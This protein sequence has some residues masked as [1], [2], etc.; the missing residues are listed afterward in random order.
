MPRLLL[1]F[2]VAH[3]R[4]Y[5]RFA[6]A[7]PVLYAMMMRKHPDSPELLAARAGFRELSLGLFAS[8]GDPLAASKANF[9]SWALLHGLAE[10]E[11]EALLDHPELS[12]DASLAISALLAG[13]SRA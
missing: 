13:L 6:R 9:A 10:L 12:A 3:P 2:F 5:L 1:H 7:H 4:S 11:R 8:I